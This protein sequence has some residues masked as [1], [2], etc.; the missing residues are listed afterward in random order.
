MYSECIVSSRSEMNGCFPTNDLFV[1]IDILEVRRC[2]IVIGCTVNE[3][4]T[5]YFDPVFIGDGVD[6]HT[7]LAKDKS[8][9]SVG[10]TFIAKIQLGLHWLVVL[11]CPIHVGEK[12]VIQVP[13]TNIG[14]G[15]PVL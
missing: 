4:C 6:S 8:I 10:G 3:F 11:P 1:L 12:V 2:S 7:G 14:L 15:C 13:F 5:T 9:E